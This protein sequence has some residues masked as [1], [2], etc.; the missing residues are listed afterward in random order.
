MYIYKK[1]GDLKNSGLSKNYVFQPFITG[2]IIVIDAVKSS[3]GEFVFMARKELVRTAN[4]A[5]LTIEI[6]NNATVNSIAKKFCETTK[7]KGC[8]NIEMIQH[9]TS[10]YLMDIN[11][12]P[13]AGVAF[14]GLA[15][16]NFVKNHVAAF[17]GQPIDCAPPVQYQGI[18][19]RKYVEVISKMSPEVKSL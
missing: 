14:S 16:Y 19:T 7:F 2:N 18:I 3:A 12:R 9:G 13:S 1:L 5:G 8:I 10:Y 17:L 4:G 6:L 15:G 11:P